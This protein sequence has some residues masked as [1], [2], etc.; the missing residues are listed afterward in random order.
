MPGSW[1]SC[2]FRG[3]EMGTQGSTA[4][5]E[6]PAQTACLSWSWNTSCPAGPGLQLMAE[7]SL[8]CAACFPRATWCSS[9]FCEPGAYLPALGRP[10]GSLR[11]C[12]DYLCRLISHPCHPR[13]LVLSQGGAGPHWACLHQPGWCQPRASPSPCALPPY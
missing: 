7:L 12:W 8:C 13:P 6:L 5:S 2:Y 1:C 3:T 10:L 11:S 4:P 9:A